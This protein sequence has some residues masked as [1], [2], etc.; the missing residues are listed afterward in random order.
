VNVTDP[1]GSSFLSLDVSVNFLGVGVDAGV[2]LGDD[3]TVGAYV[4][5][6]GG[7]EPIGAAG[8]SQYHSG[9]PEWRTST[10]GGGCIG[11]GIACAA[12]GYDSGTG[13]GGG[14]G[15]G[16]N[17]GIYENSTSARGD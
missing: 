17:A 3:G 16:G 8:A 13:F 1:A 7:G 6:G 11:P 10:T 14:V 4:G 12:G 5:G 2:E 9:E 15:V